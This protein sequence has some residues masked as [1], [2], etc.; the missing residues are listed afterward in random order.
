MDDTA[1]KLHSI[2]STIA[3]V[4]GRVHGL[5]VLSVEPP[6][7]HCLVWTVIFRRGTVWYPVELAIR[8]DESEKG[9]QHKLQA[10]LAEQLEA[11]TA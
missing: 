4:L 10:G 3:A 9:I 1:K 6:M 8:T 5:T 2:I 7:A 11:R